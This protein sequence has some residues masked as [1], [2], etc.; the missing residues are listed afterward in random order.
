MTKFTA[1]LWSDLVHE[2]GPALAR[3]GRPE[4]GRGRRSRVIAGGTLALAVAGTALGLGLTAT[5]GTP[6]AAGG[7]KV[8]TDAYTI[9]QNSSGSVLVQINQSTSLPAANSKLT[10]MGIHEQ[11]TIYNVSGAAAVSGPVACTPAPGVSGPSV[12]VLLGTDGTETIAP[13]ATA[14][15]TG[16]GTYHL[17][18]C[19]VTGD[20]GSGSAGNTGVG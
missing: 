2:H 11:V 17:A 16:V 4:S 13:G 7:G 5:G 15:N 10:A 14:G 19:K 18:S 8:V 20:A 9:T 3:A 6:T 1:R 12:K